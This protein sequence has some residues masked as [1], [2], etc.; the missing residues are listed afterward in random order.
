MVDGGKLVSQDQPR[1]TDS[2]LT[3]GQV[4]RVKL[5]SGRGDK[6]VP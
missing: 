5:K 6:L 1:R 2:E 3:V 4:A